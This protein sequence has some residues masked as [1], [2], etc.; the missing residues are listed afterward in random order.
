M[1]LASRASASSRKS[2]FGVAARAGAVVG[3]IDGVVDGVVVG[4]IVGVVVDDEDAA[5]MDAAR[6]RA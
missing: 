6:S 3:A 5:P 2:G 1:R 4:A